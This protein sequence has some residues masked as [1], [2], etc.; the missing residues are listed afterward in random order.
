MQSTPA[1]FRF[2][3]PLLAAGAYELADPRRRA[4]VHARLAQ[5]VENPETRAWQLAASVDL[6]D[7]A[8][9]AALEEAA[10][11]V[12]ARG[13]LRPAALLLD[14]ARELTPADRP[15]SAVR[16]AAEAAFLHFESGDSP[17]AEAQLRDVIAPLAAGRE[18]ARALNVLARIRTYDATHEAAELFLQVVAEAREIGRFSPSRTKAWRRA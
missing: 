17:R 4:E 11:H 5:L 13:A 6:P 3:H 7:Q 10:R 1:S 8:V 18:R 12:R 15:E 2:T 16:R 14:R 9:A